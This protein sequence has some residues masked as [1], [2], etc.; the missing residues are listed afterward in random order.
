M[1]HFVSCRKLFVVMRLVRTTFR[2]KGASVKGSGVVVIDIP[3][4]N[5]CSLSINRV[6]DTCVGRGIF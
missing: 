3:R 1:Y 6:S 2:E 4:I 5:V